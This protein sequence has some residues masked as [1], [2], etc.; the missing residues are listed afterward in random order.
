MFFEEGRLKKVSSLK[1]GIN[2]IRNSAGTLNAK[3][4]KEIANKHLAS[5]YGG[6]KKKARVYNYC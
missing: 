2:E 5:E 3:E 4:E 6:T 1:D